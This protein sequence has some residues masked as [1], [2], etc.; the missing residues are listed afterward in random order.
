MLSQ[1][2]T[3]VHLQYLR[4]WHSIL[5]IRWDPN[6]CQENVHPTLTPPPPFWIFYK[7]Q[8]GTILFV[9]LRCILALL[10]EQRRRNRSRVA[11][12]GFVLYLWHL[13]RLHWPRRP[14]VMRP[15]EHLWGVMSWSILMHSSAPK[16][17]RVVGKR[18]GGHMAPH[19]SKCFWPFAV[20]MPRCII[21]FRHDARRLFRDF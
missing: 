20:S 1:I 15:I 2:E 8:D 5:H 7:R 19:L 4:P 10:S 3:R 12:N 18:H 21:T 6:V 14:F 17:I 13:R 16:I 9:R 11:Q